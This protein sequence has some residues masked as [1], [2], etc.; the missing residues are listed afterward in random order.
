MESDWGLKLGK[1]PKST[2]R[3]RAHFE[4]WLDP[5]EICITLSH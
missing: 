1:N 5:L 3:D 2:R 4:P